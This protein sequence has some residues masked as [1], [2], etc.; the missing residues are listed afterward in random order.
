MSESTERPVFSAADG[1]R[2]SFWNMIR[3]RAPMPDVLNAL[4]E[5]EDETGGYSRA[6][7]RVRS[8]SSGT[9]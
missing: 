9:R 6:S 1:Y 5:G 2:S 8:Y 7:T 3:S 4:K